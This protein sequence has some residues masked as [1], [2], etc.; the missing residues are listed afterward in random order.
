MSFVKCLTS[1]GLYVCSAFSHSSSFFSH[2]LAHTR[3]RN[4]LQFESIQWI[5]V[6][7]FSRIFFHFSVSALF[8][9]NVSHLWQEREA[10]RDGDRSRARVWERVT[11]QKNK[12]ENEIGVCLLCIPS[13]KKRQCTYSTHFSCCS[14]IACRF[15]YNVCILSIVSNRNLI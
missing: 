5:V 2:C 3:D 12:V 4:S 13:K 15:L 11:A 6:L 10:G 9:G 14:H 8:A 7:F 1:I